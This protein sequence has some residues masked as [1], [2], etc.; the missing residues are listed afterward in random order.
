MGRTPH[1]STYLIDRH[2]YGVDESNLHRREL[3]LFVSVHHV[4]WFDVELRLLY[5]SLFK[6]LTRH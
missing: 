6:K 4:H 3:I 5:V 1:C 2:A